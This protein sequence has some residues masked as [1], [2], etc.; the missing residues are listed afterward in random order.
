LGLKNKKG[1]TLIE[2]LLV[3]SL[4]AVIGLTIYK[5][6]SN[7]VDLWNWHKAHRSDS[8][9]FLFFEKT[10][11]DLGNIDLGEW[12]GMRGERERLFFHR[13]NPS[14]NLGALSVIKALPVK[15]PLY[16]VE[17]FYSP[18]KKTVVRRVY[19]YGAQRPEY[20]KV[21]LS[22]AENVR[23]SYYVVSES[24]ENLEK[25]SSWAG[26]VPAGVE[27]EVTIKGRDGKDKSFKRVF[28]MPGIE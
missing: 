10:A 11:E 6:F 15:D 19:S 20:E 5:A 14:L 24:S 3:V 21:V 8:D 16:R 2:L 1:N 4:T 27:I 26:R 13:Y 9:V 17:Y 7:G 12:G 18:D 23:I 28:E 22:G 25:L